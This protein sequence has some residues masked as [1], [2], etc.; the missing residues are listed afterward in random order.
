MTLVE[1]ESHS[2]FRLQSRSGDDLVHDPEELERIRG[3]YDEVVIGIE[4]AVEV[5]AAQLPGTEQEGH[6]ELDIRAGSMVPGVDEDLCPLA[7]PDAMGEGGSPVGH[8]GA[9]EGRLEELVL[10][11]HP[12]TCGQGHVH[13]TESFGQALLASGETV[14][15]RVI[16][17][18][19]KPQAQDR[20]TGRLG[21]IHTF[22]EM[23]D[24][25]AGE[26]PGRD[27]RRCRACTRAPGRRWG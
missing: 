16:G 19:G 22:L 6:N 14:L 13:L 20:G 8:V 27:C 12:H 7:E 21:H 3:T 9:V 25:R 4:P 18:V 24:R 10:E 2:A 17:A 15:T 26:L 23:T 1:H 11:Q 5:E